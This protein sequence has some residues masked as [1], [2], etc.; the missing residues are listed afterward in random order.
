[1]AIGLGILASLK[2]RGE[3]K[4]KFLTF[5]SNPEWYDLASTVEGETMSIIRAV[6]QTR[7]ADWGMNTDL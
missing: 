7:R 6:E 4:Y 5:S 3:L 2:T 1:V